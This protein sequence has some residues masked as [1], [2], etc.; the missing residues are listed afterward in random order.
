MSNINGEQWAKIPGFNWEVSTHGRARHLL[1]G[2]YFAEPYIRAG[3]LF[4]EI[5]DNEGR[6]VEVSMMLLMEWAL[7]QIVQIERYDDDEGTIRVY[8]E[9]M[10]RPGSY[11]DTLTGD[12]WEKNATTG[13]WTVNGMPHKPLPHSLTPEPPTG[14][15]NPTSELDYPP[16]D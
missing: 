1:R 3:E 16:C 9:D 6:Y 4:V 12:I 10:Y 7:P 11:T 15:D 13:K 14:L 8:A 5:T 2:E